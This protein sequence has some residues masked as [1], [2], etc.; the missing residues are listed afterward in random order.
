MSFRSVFHQVTHLGPTGEAVLWATGLVAVAVADPRAPALFDVCLFKAL[1]I[2]FCPGCGLGHAVG[3]LARGEML[4]ALKT[5]P[6]APAVV[7][8][9]I[10][11][12]VT[13]LRT[14]HFG[15]NKPR[16]RGSTHVQSHQVPA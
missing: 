11:R 10:H 6:F 1:G 14:Q 9:L 13:L 8:V 2:S 12:I 3:F 5:H 15:E 7:A 16:A 4:L